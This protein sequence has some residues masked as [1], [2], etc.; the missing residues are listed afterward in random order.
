MPWPLRAA[1][2]VALARA[3]GTHRIH[4][5][6]ASATGLASGQRNV[7]KTKRDSM[8][9]GRRGRSVAK[10]PFTRVSRRIRKVIVNADKAPLINADLG[11]QPRSQRRLIPSP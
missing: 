2:P 7:L 10:G 1:E 8:T 9:Q 4:A 5:A 11:I 3:E 6:L